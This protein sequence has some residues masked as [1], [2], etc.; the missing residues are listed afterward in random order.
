MWFNVS[1]VLFDTNVIELLSDAV[2]QLSNT[3]K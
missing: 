3:F 2:D 1:D